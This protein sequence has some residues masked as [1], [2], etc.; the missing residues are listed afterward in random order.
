MQPINHKNALSL[1]L[2]QAEHIHLALYNVKICDPTTGSGALPMG[3][4][5][6]IFSIKELIAYETSNEWAGFNNLK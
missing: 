2:S 6:E 1:N 3:L 4:L 5:Q